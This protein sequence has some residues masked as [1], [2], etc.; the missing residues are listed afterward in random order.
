MH[1][2]GHAPIPNGAEISR[3]C[4][5]HGVRCGRKVV[6]SREL[7]LSALGFCRAGVC[8]GK[9]PSGSPGVALGTGKNLSGRRGGLAFSGP[10][11]AGWS[12][13]LTPLA[14]R[15][16]ACPCQ[17]VFPFT[18]P[19]P[20]LTSCLSSPPQPLTRSAPGP[21]PSPCPPSP[22]PGGDSSKV[23]LVLARVSWGE[24]GPVFQNGTRAY[25]FLTCW[26][27]T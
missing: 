16:W 1:C 11:V 14:L 18:R 5:T 24:K 4:Q 19:A 9:I 8:R 13:A 27:E 25:A 6:L 2:K 10:H 26:V 17:L 21:P 22:G 23:F 7:G 12:S 20:R 15:A 3:D